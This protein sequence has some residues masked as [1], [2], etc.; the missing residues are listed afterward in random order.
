MHDLGGVQGFGPVV[1]ETDEPVFHAEWERRVFRIFVAVA[2]AK[3]SAGGRH[4]IERMGPVWYLSSPYYEHWLAGTATGLVEAGVIDKTEL[5]ARL[6]APF[7]LSSPVRAPRLADPGASTDVYRFAVGDEVRVREW[8]PLGHT[9]QP[10]TC[11]DRR[12]RSFVSIAT[13]E[14]RTSKCVGIP[15]DMMKYGW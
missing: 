1:V 3:A 14:R 11:G 4:A 2:L 10:G 13:A 7:D 6:G 8:H 15:D 12:G 5:D 9:R